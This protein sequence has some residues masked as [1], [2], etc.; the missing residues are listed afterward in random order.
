MVNTFNSKYPPISLDDSYGQVISIDGYVVN[1]VVDYLISVEL[2]TLEGGSSPTWNVSGSNPIITHITV[3]A[4]N[5]TVRDFDSQML[6]NY[7]KLVRNSSFNGLSF[8]IPMTDIQY[9]LKKRIYNTL[10]P[11]YAYSQVKIELSIADLSDIT[12]GSPSGSAGTTLYLNEVSLKR[13]QV[14][15]PLFEFKQLQVNTALSLKGDNDLTNFLAVD[16][17]YKSLFF[18]ATTGQSY[19]DAT[20]SL[21]NYIDLILNVSEL[22]KD[23]YWASMKQENQNLFGQDV[24]K[25]FAMMIFMEDNDFSQLLPLSNPVITKS[26]NLKV[27]TSATGYLY[28]LKNIYS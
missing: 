8:S 5:T 26:A 17:Y 6:T 28:M 21:V 24:P 25:G 19:G 20:D 11:S 7:M 9:S 2:G 27:N 13:E 14:T 1:G 23:Q 16:G 15:F 12:T 3:K 4:N 18:M 22:I 10:F